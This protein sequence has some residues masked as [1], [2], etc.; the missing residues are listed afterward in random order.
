MSEHAPAGRWRKTRKDA[1]DVGLT[2]R[3]ECA[4]TGLPGPNGKL[5]TSVGDGSAKHTTH[6]GHASTCRWGAE[7]SH[8]AAWRI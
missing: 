5:A 3:A 4:T 8:A 7:L 6:R 2:T 1:K